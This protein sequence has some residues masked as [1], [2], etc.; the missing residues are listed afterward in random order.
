MLAAV[1]YAVHANFVFLLP[2]ASAHG[3]HNTAQLLQYQCVTLNLC[4]LSYWPQQS[5][6]KLTLHLKIYGV[7]H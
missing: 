3:A 2:A 5:R 4:L 7:I 6:A 1:K